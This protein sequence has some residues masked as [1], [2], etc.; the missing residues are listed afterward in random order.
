MANSSNSVRIQ[1]EEI[2]KTHSVMLRGYLR[3]LLA[4]PHD[5]DD[6]TQE[7]CLTVLKSPEILLRGSDPGAYLR[8]IARHLASRHHRLVK[9]DPVLE[10]VMDVAW[11]QEPPA[12]SEEVRSALAECLSRQPA[13]ARRMLAWRYGEGLTSRSIGERLRIS[14]DAAR[15]ALARAR[16]ALTRCLKGRVSLS[17][18]GA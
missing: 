18:G 3:H 14:A 12:F 2:L 5:A 6:L 11:E 8:G 7:A 17:E 13:R 9:R 1:A 16:Q 15:M 4:S 10:A